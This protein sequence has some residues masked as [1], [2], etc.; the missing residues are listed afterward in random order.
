MNSQI[1]SRLRLAGLETQRLYSVNTNRVMIKVRCPEDRLT[2][3][4]EVLRL[5]MKTIDG[6]FAPFREDTASHFVPKNDMLDIPSVYQGKMVSLLGSKDRQTIIDFIIG[7]RIR[8]SGAELAHTTDV[9]KMIQ[10]RVPLHMHRKLDAIYNVWVT[11]WRRENWTGKD[12]SGIDCDD[13]VHSEF[14]ESRGNGRNDDDSFVPHCLTRL[15]VGAFHQPLDSI[16][17]YFGEQVTFYFAWLEH[18]SWHLLF[19]AV[20]GLI[21][22][23][24]Q[25]STNDFDHWIRPYF[26]VAVMI[27]TFM[28]LINWRKR[29]NY[30]AHRWGSMDVKVQETPRPEFYGEYVVDEVT[31]EWVVKYPAWK[32]YLKY[33]I[34]VPISLFFTG[35]VMVLIL[36]VHANRDLQMANYVE[37]LSNPD[38]EPFQFEF[39]LTNIGREAELVDMPITR[40]L[41]LDPQF[42]VVLGALP[43]MLGISIPIMNVILM[44]VATKLNN[45][46]NY[47]TE[48]EYRTHLI[49]KVFSFRFVSQFGTVYYYAAI[50][51]GSRQ[52][53]ENGIIRMGTSLIMYTT[54]AYYWNIILQVYIF[55]LIRN[56]RR[57]LYKKRLRQELKKIELEEESL[58][59]SSVSDI[60]EREVRLINK[61]MLLDQ[62]QDDAW[63]EVMR[64]AHDSF[65]EYITSVLQFSFVACFSVV[66]P[67]TPLFVLF[68]YLISMRFDAY[69]ICRGRQRPL[70]QKTGGMGVWEDLLHIVAV[71]AVLT[72]C[73][74]IA[75][76]NSDFIEFTKDVGTMGIFAIVVC[77]EHVMLL[78]KYVMQTVISPLPKSVRD[79]LKREHHNQET[80]RYAT[81]RLKNGVKKTESQRS[82]FRRGKK[83][84][85][86]ESV[87]LIS[88]DFLS[89]ARDSF[90][91]EGEPGVLYSC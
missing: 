30:L 78:I 2:D 68:N 58:E 59:K 12:W 51:T 67:I 81:M 86:D 79:E 15:F 75:F 35:F 13:S 44:I 19:M 66:L 29:N 82:L 50:S 83:D 70:A 39:S 45:F 63:F 84:R 21:V 80:E 14:G 33:L 71:I 18:C 49:I 48:S 54:V 87:S 1:W 7:S 11:Y 55:M 34:S 17:E 73:W 90:E 32:R 6:G 40:E 76:T 47:R 5:K 53:I 16:E 64:P 52:A 10:A 37:Q 27:W 60:E 23:A 62:A 74:L 38:A 85:D 8:D 89:P 42:W 88:K 26:A 28:V 65:P 77:W 3:V 36:N 46:E 43:V 56:I 22:T 31:Q 57:F 4:A 41:L 24:C 9:G 72:N 20:L 61:R 69:K 91:D 25:L